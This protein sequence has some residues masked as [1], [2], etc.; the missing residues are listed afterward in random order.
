M[1][2]YL[3]VIGRTDTG[4]STHCPD[5]PGCA[6]TGATVEETVRW[7]LWLLFFMGLGLV[8]MVFFPGIVLW[9]PQAAGFM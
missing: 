3:I 2:S 7:D 9:L 8:A 6:A 4:Y 5:V 1:E